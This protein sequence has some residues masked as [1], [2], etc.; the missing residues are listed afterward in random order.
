MDC[1]EIEVQS[2]QLL[3]VGL[4]CP[5][6]AFHA[7]NDMVDQQAEASE[8]V[9]LE[10]NE[11]AKVPRQLQASLAQDD[12]DIGS[13]SRSQADATVEQIEELLVFELVEAQGE[14][15]RVGAGVFESTSAEVSDAESERCRLTSAG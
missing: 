5:Q 8:L 6:N 10:E 9:H 13:L 12:R 14:K 1:I 2:I 3:V 4:V 11:L 15:N 7:K